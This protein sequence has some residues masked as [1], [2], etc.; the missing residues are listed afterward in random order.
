MACAVGPNQLPIRGAV[1]ASRRIWERGSPAATGSSEDGEGSVNGIA[2]FSKRSWPTRSPVVLDHYKPGKGGYVGLDNP[3]RELF[4]RWRKEHH[5]IWPGHMEA[6]PDH[7]S[8][9]QDHKQKNRHMARLMDAVK[10]DHITDMKRAR[11]LYDAA[12][13][14]FEAACALAVDLTSSRR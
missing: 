12:D 2:E 10:L 13:D 1:L 7:P 5:A 4:K 9:D 6:E 8:L 11:K 14:D 3:D